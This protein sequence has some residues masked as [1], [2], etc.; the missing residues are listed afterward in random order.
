MLFQPGK[1]QAQPGG[2]DFIQTLEKQR[3]SGGFVLGYHHPG[4]IISLKGA[5]QP[6]K[7]SV[8][9]NQVPVFFHKGDLIFHLFKFFIGKQI[10]IQLIAEGSEVCHIGP[11]IQ[12]GFPIQLMVWHRRYV[13]THG[14]QRVYHGGS[15]LDLHPLR[16]VGVVTGP[17][18]RSKGQHAGV[19]PG[20]AAGAGLKQNMRKF[21]GQPGIQ[22]VNSQNVAMHHF[23]LIR[24]ASSPGERL[25]DIPVHIP[26][27]IG[28][29]G[30]T[31]HPG[32]HLVDGV[33]HLFPGII[34]HML[35]A[36]M[37]LKSSRHSD[38]PVGVGPVQVA[39]FV[40]HLQFHPEAEF[41]AQFLHLFRKSP[42]SV[43][44]FFQI[45]IPVSQP[46][47][48]VI[49]GSEP[50]VIQNKQLRARLFCFSRD[51]KN[52]LFGEVKIGGL[53]VVQQN[54]PHL[55]SPFSPHQTR[56][57]QPVEGLAHT[58]QSPAAVYHHHLRRLE[59]FSRMQFPGEGLRL[60]S[61]HHPGHLMGIHL[62]LRQKASAVHQAEAV[63]L[64][65]L[66]CSLR[67]LQCQK[68]ILL[69]AAGSPQALN[70]LNTHLQLSVLHVPLPGPGAGQLHHFKIHIGEFHTGAQGPVQDDPLFSHMEKAGMTGHHRIIPV[71]GV[72]KYQIRIRQR[73]MERD[74]QSLRF[75]IL[76]HIGGRQ[77][78]NALLPR[79]DFM[80]YISE[81]GNSA[82]VFLLHRHRRAPVI[83]GSIGRILLPGKLQGQGSRLRHIYRHQRTGLLLM[84]MMERF[85]VRNRTAKV[86]MLHLPVG[87]NLHDITDFSVCQMKFLR[88]L[89]KC[90][91]H[92]NISFLLNF[93]NDSFFGLHCLSIA[94][95]CGYYIMLYK[96]I[97]FF[98]L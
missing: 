83:P 37:A 63:N 72:G 45:H 4:G 49:A 77:R 47:V 6:V 69:R 38:H 18:L 94:F 31:D 66:L 11:G 25:C 10:Q 54:R 76:L 34:Q 86:Q 67:S 95:S 93:R 16:S 27:D 42:D 36:G 92:F 61:H 52:L 91:R 88:L 26:L 24:R 22:I 32:N 90:D 23:S 3:Q 15:V 59:G 71:D 44:Q 81:G 87:H 55:V 14:N 96:K 21:R 46:P 89:M 53:P 80:G 17:G 74:F 97:L 70:R 84:Q 48:I 51:G 40:H 41:Q 12:R 28:N 29:S 60:N 19:K 82:A 57:V 75:L 43:G 2:V 85:P 8:Q 39:V 64:S 73:I 98:L 30:I 7:I 58:V 9:L 20:A 65:L 68:W 1:P 56:P 35:M 62:H 33:H 78:R 5:L 50:A 13:G 79:K